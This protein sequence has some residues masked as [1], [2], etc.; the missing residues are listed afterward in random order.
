[1]GKGVDATR[2][3]RDDT[4]AATL[5]VIR[6]YSAAMR[7]HDVSRVRAVATSASRDADNGADLVDAIDEIIGTKPE[8]IGGEEEAG[9][10]FIGATANTDGEPPFLVIDI[11]GGSTEFV[12]G[13]DS[14][15]YATSVEIGS[16]RLTDRK[17]PDRPPSATQMTDATMHA[18]ALFSSVQLPGAPRTV[19][20]VAGTFTSLSAINLGLTVYDRD[21]IHGTELSKGEVKELITE[22]SVLTIEETASIPSLDP[23][24]A[25]VLLA[26]AVLVDSAARVAMTESILVSE[27]GLLNALATSL[28]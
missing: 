15:S 6:T 27:Y 3:F 25:P 11:G 26:G 9:L 13:V 23:K 20:G 28:L 12:F 1:M 5:D 19:I 2:R 4:V 17:L 22:L 18:D 21:A 7:H 14:P 24:R 8:I 16:V 10:A